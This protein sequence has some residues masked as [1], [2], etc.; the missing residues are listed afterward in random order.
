[1]RKKILSETR[2]DTFGPWVEITA[3]TPYD[4]VGYSVHV[5]RGAGRAVTVEVG[6]GLEQRERPRG[7][8]EVAP[9]DPGPRISLVPA[10]S[11]AAGTRVAA[12]AKSPHGGILATIGVDLI[13]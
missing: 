8:F 7:T 9:A 11:L 5:S 6:V 1:M 10:D 3:A 13:R 12:R 2:S 4:A